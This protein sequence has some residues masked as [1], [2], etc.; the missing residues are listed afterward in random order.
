MPTGR[1][2]VPAGSGLPPNVSSCASVTRV[3]GS[4]R[5]QSRHGLSLLQRPTDAYNYQPF[6]LLMTPQERGT[7]FTNYEYDINEA[8][9]LYAEVLYNRT[10]SGFQIAPLP[11]DALADDVVISADSYYNPFGFD[12]GG[13]TTGN[14]NLTVRL[15]ALGN[16][17]S[18]TSSDSKV[19]KLGARG[20]LF[21]S[22]WNYD[23]LVG[24]S[25]LD[26]TASVSGYLY[27]PALAGAFGP[28]FDA[29]GGV[30]HVRHAGESDSA[31]PVH[32]GQHLQPD[33]SGAGRGA[34]HDQLG[35]RHRSYLYL[36]AG[37]VRGGRQAV[38]HAGRRRARVGPGGLHRAAWRLQCR[39]PRHGHAAAV[40]ELLARAGNLHGTEQWRIQRERTLGRIL[41]AAGEGRA[42]RA[43]VEP[44]GR[45]ALLR[46]LDV[47][48]HDEL[49]Q[50]S[51]NTGR[52]TT[53][54]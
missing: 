47:R 12:F 24:Y 53:S 35:L 28:S 17:R 22:E 51:W 9:Q 27:Q 31:G 25:R 48:Q 36:E 37:F 4:C 33:G 43:G 23:F 5:R 8:V 38:R 40:P 26:Q 11:F 14:P 46:V 34:R 1:F 19:A 2:Y 49:D 42:G 52:S 50:S 45:F 3:A 18:K 7:I 54:C 10:R 41:P 30:I 29:G 21:G 39:L 15:E 13:V 20:P 44:D 16:R 32:A 6:N